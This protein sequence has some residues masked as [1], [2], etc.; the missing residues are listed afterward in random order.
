M[1]MANDMNINVK[2]GANTQGFSQGMKSVQGGLGASGASM[3]KFSMG[4]VAGFA[5][6]GLAAA[7]AGVML[8]KFISKAT[9][10][11]I[12]FEASLTKTAAI[13]GETS[14]G[15]IPEITEEVKRL[16]AATKST[17]S[18]VAEAAQILALA[19]LGSEDIVDKKA[20]ENLNNLAIAAGVSIPEAASVAISSLKG[21]QMETSEL[22]RV[23]DVLLNTMTSTFTNIQGLGESMK[24]LGPTAATTGISI[25][26]AAAAVGKLGDAG[27]Q[28]SMAGTA[29]RMAITKLLKPTD[30]ARKLM[31][32][33]GLDIFTLTPAGQAAKSALRTVA[34][35][36]ENSKV[37]AEATNAQMKAL[38]EELSD[39]SIEQQTNSLAIMKIK[40]RAEKEGRELNKRELEQID[41]LESANAD[42]NITMAER[43]IEQQVVGAE[44]KRVNETLSA[45][46]A[47]YTSLNKTVQ[48]QTTGLTSLSDVFGQ[49]RDAGATTNQMLEIFGVRG[50]TA[51]NILLANVDGMDELT[52]SNLKAQ[53]GMGK[54]AEMVETMSTTTLFATQSLSAEWEG[55][56]LKVGEQFGPVLRDSVIP[57]LKDM[58]VALEPSIPAFADMA[59]QIA[60]LIPMLAENLIPIIGHLIDFFTLIAPIIK[61]VGYALEFMFVFLEPV[62]RMLAGI[63]QVIVSI[64]EL[65]FDG[66][67]DGLAQ[68]FGAWFEVINPVWRVLKSIASMLGFDLEGF[69]DDIEDSTGFNVGSAAAGAGIGMMFGGPVGAAVGGVIGGMFFAEG[70]IVSEPTMGVVG[71]AGPEAVIPIEKIDGII[72]SS[73][74][75]AGNGSIGSNTPSITLNGGITIGAG[76]NINKAEAQEAFE[77]AMLATL[78]SNKWRATRGMI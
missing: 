58:I 9:S 13:M 71:E 44:Q 22:G 1:S 52:A 38:N 53:E 47:E 33:L 30:T 40:R 35:E 32:D 77:K 6:V 61:L 8:F 59:V 69:G 7:G 65:D 15:A 74:A 56:L 25:E 67:I 12:D 42:L 28:G 19:G 76:N 17:V 18:E 21:F 23:N 2:V 11:F 45:Q 46:K 10:V 26:E 72:A 39:L 78:T 16:G 57:A 24:F 27:L 64:I 60:E 70:G 49:L 66:I 50:G 37:Q 14:M 63:A 29:L 34:A 48:E 31:N 51:A 20:L 5:A 75:K 4:A 41:R 68:A 55:F 73:M 36:L 62:W 43:R 3:S 54:T